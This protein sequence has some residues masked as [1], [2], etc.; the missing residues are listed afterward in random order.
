VIRSRKFALDTQL[1]IHSF[2]DADASAQLDRFRE[3]FATAEYLCAI[4]AQELRAGV[5]SDQDRQALENNVIRIFERNGRS[6][7]PSAGAWHR[8]GDVLARMA[9]DEGLELGRVSKSFSNDILLAL[10]CREHGCV[11]VTENERDFRRIQRYV[12]FEFVKPWPGVAR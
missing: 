2:R 8:S 6:F 7:S 5:R 9:Q 3:G 12:E 10:S 1:F 11:L 4:V